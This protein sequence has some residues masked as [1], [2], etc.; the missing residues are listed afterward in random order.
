M[1]LP[2][3][4]VDVRKESANL[5]R[6]LPPFPHIVRFKPAPKR[7]RILKLFKL[8][9]MIP[10]FA[11]FGCVEIHADCYRFKWTN[12]KWAQQLLQLVRRNNWRS[13]EGA[14]MKLTFATTR[15]LAHCSPVQYICSEFLPNFSHCGSYEFNISLGDSATYFIA[16]LLTYPPICRSSSVVVGNSFWPTELPVELIGN[17][18]DRPSVK[19]Q[20]TKLP[21]VLRLRMGII[22]NALEVVDHIIK[23]DNVFIAIA[24]CSGILEG[25]CPLR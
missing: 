20:T 23:V 4:I 21:N 10:Q 3:F 6:S 16:S 2:R 18:L 12:F 7:R 24:K 8:L 22:L 11:R 9:D 19:G 14:K 5:A 15:I 13:G 25:S 1:Q 17:W